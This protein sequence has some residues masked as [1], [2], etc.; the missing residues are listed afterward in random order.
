M[1]GEALRDGRVIKL[2]RTFSTSIHCDIKIYCFAI[3]FI[4]R[5]GLS[6]TVVFSA[7]SSFLKLM[8]GYGGLSR[9]VF[10][11]TETPVCDPYRA[12]DTLYERFFSR[13]VVAIRLAFSQY[14]EL[15]P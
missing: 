1:I 9:S 5:V 15:Q 6:L 12:S 8:S 11:S 4:F 13:R 14:S 2:P 10:R 3:P 7:K